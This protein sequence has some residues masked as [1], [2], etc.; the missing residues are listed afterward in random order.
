MAGN[1]ETGGKVAYF[2]AGKDDLLG[3]EIDVVAATEDDELVGE[4]RW[5]YP[6]L[7]VDFHDFR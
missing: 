1:Q 3:V 4:S 5:P 2:P 7:S 6:Y